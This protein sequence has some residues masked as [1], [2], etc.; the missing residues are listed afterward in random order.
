MKVA[1]RTIAGPPLKWVGSKRR[2]VPE[3]L[4]RLPEK[5]GT[6]YEPFFGGGAVFFA[7][8]SAGRFKRAVV[9]DMND[10]LMR[11]YAQ[12]EID[13][14]GVIDALRRHV[15]E[16][17]YY[18]RI[19]AQVPTDL[20]PN[21]RAARVIYLNKTCFNGLYRVNKKGEFNV[22]FGDY[23]DPKICDEENLRAVS[24]AFGATSILSV[25]FEVVTQEAK[26][27]DAVYSDPP[28]IPVSDSSNFTAYASGGFDARAHERLRNRARYLS[29]KGVHVLLSNSDTPHSRELYR[30]FKIEEVQVGRSINSVGSKRGKIGE[31]LI[32]G[33]SK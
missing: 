5:I 16:E 17:K 18:Y 33:N 22:P 25:D 12:L 32:S 1:L 11:M 10:E 6:Y 31:L 29:G 7:L 23:S 28:Y 20:S 3:I 27:G 14:G 13:V 24:E 15:C 8:A 21:A 9:N 19:R 4:K 2:L 26:K 30:D